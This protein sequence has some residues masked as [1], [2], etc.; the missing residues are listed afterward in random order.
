GAGWQRQAPGSPP[1]PRGRAA[2][3]PWWGSF[4]AVADRLEGGGHTAERIGISGGIA[5]LRRR[6]HLERLALHHRLHELP[7]AGGVVDPGRLAITLLG[8]GSELER[9]GIDRCRH[10]AVRLDRIA[11]I[12]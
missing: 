6:R 3:E 4:A 10:L 5:L 7:L 1:P 11:D 8:R 9:V 2:P 12:D